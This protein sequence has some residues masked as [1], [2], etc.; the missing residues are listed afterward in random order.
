MLKPFSEDITT[1]SEDYTEIKLNL[2]SKQWQDL[3]KEIAHWKRTGGTL[4]AKMTGKSDVKEVK[5]LIAKRRSNLT[6]EEEARLY[7]TPGI[8]PP[9]YPKDPNEESYFYH[10]I[11]AI[12]QLNVSA[13]EVLAAVDKEYDDESTLTERQRNIL[14]VG[15][16]QE[17]G[18]KSKVIATI[19]EKKVLFSKELAEW[20]ARHAG[21]RLT[22]KVL[23]TIGKFLMPA[24]NVIWTA[25]IGWDAYKFLKARPGMMSDELIKA[26]KEGR[27]SEENIEK[28]KTAFYLLREKKMKPAEVKKVM[29]KYSEKKNVIPYGEFY[30]KD[31]GWY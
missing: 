21:L 5:E 4:H 11:R 7:Q 19:T 17:F 22:S 25:E 16:G 6:E 28:V 12:K 14:R 30:H 9:W 3:R 29:E 10:A 2:S 18:E 27:V 31:I 8:I 1:G 26:L 23:S 20:I 13:A 24:I 15:W